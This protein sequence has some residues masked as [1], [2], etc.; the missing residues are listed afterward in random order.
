MKGAG[1]N[2]AISPAS[3]LRPFGGAKSESGRRVPSG[4]AAPERLAARTEGG[5]DPETGHDDPL[6]DQ[7]SNLR[8]TTQLLLP[9]KAIALLSAIRSDRVRATFGT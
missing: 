7:P 9:P 8:R 3:R 4:E 2:S 1:E 6:H 5:D